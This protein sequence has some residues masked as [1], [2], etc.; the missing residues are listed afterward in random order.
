MRLAPQASL[1]NWSVWP[2]AAA[3][4]I[5]CGCAGEAERDRLVPAPELARA[6]VAAVLE[7]WNEGNASERID[8]LPVRI[9]VIDKHRKVGQTLESFEILGEAPGATS[10]CFAVRL[11][12]NNPEAEEKVRYVVIGLDPL[13]VFRHEDFEMLSHW[14]H[15]MPAEDSEPNSADDAETSTLNQTR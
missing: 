9:Q 2:V 11:K 5:F 6:A 1:C 4:L 14:D 15:I 7:D 8:K 3:A 13:W 12:L 10:R